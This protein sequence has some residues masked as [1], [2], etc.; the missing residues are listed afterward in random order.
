MKTTFRRKVMQGQKLGRTIGF[1]TVNLNVGDF[2]R[3][4]KQGVYACEARIAKKVWKGALHFGPKQGSPTPVLEI[5]IL[6]FKGSLY[7]KFITF[8][9]LKKI[10]EARSFKSLKELQR[11]I[12]NDLQAL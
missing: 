10:R 7:G 3:H 11:Q 4:F 8:R 1:P 5:H 6:N 12:K 9:I 2:A